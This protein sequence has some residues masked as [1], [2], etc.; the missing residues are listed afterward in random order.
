MNHPYLGATHS[1]RPDHRR[2]RSTT[3]TG[4]WGS[5]APTRT[6]WTWAARRRR[7]EAADAT[8]VW[9][10]GLLLPVVQALRRGRAEPGAPRHAR[11]QRPHP[12]GDARRRARAD[13]RLPHRGAALDRALRAL[14]RRRAR[15][16]RRGPVGVHRGRWCGTRSAAHEAGRLRGRGPHGPRLLRRRSRCA[17]RHGHGGRRTASTPTSPAPTPQVRGSL[18]CPLASTGLRGLVRGPLHDRG[19]RRR[20]TRAV[21]RPVTTARPRGLHPE[22]ASPRRR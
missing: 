18:N 20:R 11:G 13:R 21:Y 3:A 22:S 15:G 8:E 1:Q 9:Q 2:R 5:P 17:S 14:R 7:R 4:S 16:S 12:Q 10:E 6:T 19:R